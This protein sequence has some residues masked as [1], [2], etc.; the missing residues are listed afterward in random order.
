[1][2]GMLLALSAAGAMAREVSFGKEV[3]PLLTQHCVSCHQGAAAPA[4]LDLL[5]KAAYANL[6]GVPSTGSPQPRV[7]PADPDKSYLMHK[8]A[9]THMDVGG[10][11]ATMPLGAPPLEPAQIALIRQWIAEGARNN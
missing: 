5:P 8:L 10:Q 11:G 9:G 2:T 4:G 3:R 7:A 6:A 1:M